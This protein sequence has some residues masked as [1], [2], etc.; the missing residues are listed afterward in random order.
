MEYR[1]VD[2]CR[3]GP[4]CTSQVSV[5]TGPIYASGTFGIVMGPY[6]EDKVQ[7]E[8]VLKIIRNGVAVPLRD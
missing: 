5:H 1:R 7:A 3:N 8:T 2:Q 6:S 4:L